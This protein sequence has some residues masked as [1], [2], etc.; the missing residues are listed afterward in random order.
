VIPKTGKTPKRVLLEFS[1]AAVYPIMDEL[2][3]LQEQNQY[4]EKFI[5][6]TRDFY[7]NER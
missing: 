5:E 7:L 6:L 2:V 4:S 1:V 3:I